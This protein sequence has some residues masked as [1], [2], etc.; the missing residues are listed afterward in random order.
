METVKP[1]IFT[2]DNYRTYL[3]DLYLYHKE[4]KGKVSFRFLSRQAGF[5]SPNFFKLVIDGKRNLSN[6]SIDKVAGAFKL[7]KEERGLFRNLVM[8]NQATTS[9]E[10]R[11][12]AEGLISTNYYKKVNPLKEAQHAYYTNWYYVP[13]RELAASPYFVSD[14]EWV[15]RQLTPSI[16]T[17]EAK[18]ALDDL[19]SLGLLKKDEEGKYTQ[20]ESLVSTGDEV[21]SS[22]VVQFHREMMQKAGEALDIISASE[23]EISSVTF[24]LSPENF[25]RFKLMIQ[26]FRKEL[27]ALADAEKSQTR[28]YQLNFQLFP[29]SKDTNPGVKTGVKK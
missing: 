26:A 14:P 1:N 18:K 21:V 10:K 5:K 17:H 7:N 23:R 19:E 16:T 3:K 20:S 15:A 27:L 28:V 29:L 8:L 6:D 12:F 25:N 11:H 22:L 24:G 2:Y 13:I 9:D 4:S